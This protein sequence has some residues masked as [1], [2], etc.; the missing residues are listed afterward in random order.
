MLSMFSLVVVTKLLYCRV[1][2]RLCKKTFLNLPVS[3]LCLCVLQA[4][5]TEG[6]VS[7]IPTQAVHTEGPVSMIPTQAVPTEGPVSM[8]PTQAVGFPSQQGNG[9]TSPLKC[10]VC[11][12]TF[13]T[14]ANLTRHF[15]VLHQGIYKYSC[16]YCGRNFRDSSDVRAHVKIHG[17]AKWPV[18]GTK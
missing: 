5:H 8:I 13:A 3:L 1:G 10:I 2:L 4:V 9:K 6:P 7:M 16:P 15:R 18:T 17:S 14:K 12:K 11:D